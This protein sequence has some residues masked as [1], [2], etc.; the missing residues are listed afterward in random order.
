MILGVYG[1]SSNDASTPINKQIN[2]IN[3][4][5]IIGDHS[6]SW[7]VNVPQG[8]Y[9]AYAQIPSIG[10]IMYSSSILIFNGSNPSCLSEP[11]L[12]LSPSFLPT[13]T[14][15]SP[16]SSSLGTTS[17]SSATNAPALG[18][19]TSSNS[20]S[21]GGI[22]GAVI[23]AVAGLAA[24]AALILLLRRCR[25][26]SANGGLGNTGLFEKRPKG[27][28]AIGSRGGSFSSAH[29]RS[30]FGAARMGAAPYRVESSTSRAAYPS[31]DMN[32]HAKSVESDES[33]VGPSI[34]NLWAQNNDGPFASPYDAAA[35]LPLPL[36][37]HVANMGRSK[38]DSSGSVFSGS[39]ALNSPGGFSASAGIKPSR[40]SSLLV[41]VDPF[42]TQPNTPS[43]RPSGEYYDPYGQ[44]VR[45]GQV[46]VQLFSPPLNGSNA[47]SLGSQSHQ[48]VPRDISSASSS[49]PDLAADDLPA[50]ATALAVGTSV[51]RRAPPPPPLPRTSSNEGRT[52]GKA[53]R[54]PAP[55]YAPSVSG[56]T[57][58]L[59]PTT[60]RS[61][62]T[63]SDVATPT[64]AVGP[65]PGPAFAHVPGYSIGG[66]PGHQF[67]R[68]G[69]ID[70]QSRASLAPSSSAGNDWSS[71]AA[72][73]HSTPSPAYS[74]TQL[75]APH[76]PG[77]HWPELNHKSSFGDRQVHYLIPDPPSHEMQ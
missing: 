66:G 45:Q 68:R 17:S 59:E 43:P 3:S 32:T 35:R 2:T 77:S 11:A 12:P 41:P 7:T 57:L 21:T 6:I 58:E 13:S 47:N 19:V 5:D 9:L 4:G 20:M 48:G 22:V 14:S 53:T 46:P 37:T 16:T 74:G 69:S 10:A 56:E 64:T 36:D 65:G 44:N 52:R 42:S 27:A 55:T 28:V 8:A 39:T 67:G 23:G 50:A 62:G 70:Q 24:L 51:A 31:A 1:A 72:H 60:P 49:S 63:N 54:K 26:R 33:A 30:E 71:A 29:G 15:T 34:E 25:S 73:S 75:P 76:A 38:H 18:A 40:H 61:T